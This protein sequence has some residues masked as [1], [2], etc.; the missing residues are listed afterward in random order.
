M[1]L[2]KLH[3]SNL[4]HNL[5]RESEMKGREARAVEGFGM[6]PLICSIRDYLIG[7]AGLSSAVKPNNYSPHTHG[8][9]QTASSAVA[10]IFSQT[11]INVF[12]IGSLF[13]FGVK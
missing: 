11:L 1:I 6:F 3:T 5:G 2:D 12:T 8:A 9:R 10:D 4:V 7:K 13:Q